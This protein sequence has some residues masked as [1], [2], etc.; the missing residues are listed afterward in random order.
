MKKGLI[1]WAVAGMLVACVAMAE[2]AAPAAA[3]AAAKPVAAKHA[4]AKKGW[5]GELSAPVAGADASI[6]AVLTVKKPV[7]KTY[8]LTS[9]DA[10]VTASIKESVGK[11]VEVSGEVSKDEAS[12]AV[13]KCTEAKGA[14][15]KKH[16]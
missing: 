1:R 14:G 12:I 4:D 2:E 8:N 10:A 6:L 9:T 3:P 7:E 15:K 5:K 13:T 16:E 11:K